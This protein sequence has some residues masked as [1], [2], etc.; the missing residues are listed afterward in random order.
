MFLRASIRYWRARISGG[1]VFPVG[2]VTL[3]YGAYLSLLG[4]DLKG[5]LAYS[6]I[7]HRSDYPAVRS[8]HAMSTIAGVFHII[9]HAVFRHALHGGGD[10][11]PRVWHARHAASTAFKIFYTAVLGI[12]A[13]GSM[14]GV[15]LLNGFLSK[16]MF[17]AE[18]IQLPR[19]GAYWWILPVF[20]TMAG[21]LS[22]AY[23]ARFIHDVFFGGEPIDLPR[24]PQEPPR[25]MHSVD[26]LVLI[27]LLV[28]LFPQYTVGNILRL[29]TGAVLRRRCR[30][31]V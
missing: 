16:E 5:L 18:A 9:N 10:R 11:R 24:Q 3:V 26:I 30:I 12:V 20:A 29:A 6:T 15:P 27:C 7:S 21:V 4:N 8:R 28:G 17:F 1:I 31:F 14:A 13:A 23:S 22:V 2:A 19:F 25:W